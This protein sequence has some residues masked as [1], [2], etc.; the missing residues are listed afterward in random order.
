MAEQGRKIVI[1]ISIYLIAKQIVNLLLGAGFGSLL[2]PVLIVVFLYLNLWEY[3]HYAAAAVIA[4]TALRYLPGNIS[5][6]PGT[7]LYLTEGII[8]FF[9]AAV[10]I[11]SQD[12]RMYFKKSN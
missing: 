6:L 3:T 2:I 4:L 9:A 1:G 12:V 5:G 7:W 8:D 10:L 11:F